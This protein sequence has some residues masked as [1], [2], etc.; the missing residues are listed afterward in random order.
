M[1]K[2]CDNCFLEAEPSDFGLC[3]SCGNETFLEDKPL[4][5]DSD[6]GAEV[7]LDCGVM[8]PQLAK[9]LKTFPLREPDRSVDGEDCCNWLLE[10]HDGEDYFEIEYTSEGQIEI[11]TMVDGETEHWTLTGA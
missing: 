11:M 8:P 2:T 3:K 1:K 5:T 10:W 7:A 4:T 6:E 9:I